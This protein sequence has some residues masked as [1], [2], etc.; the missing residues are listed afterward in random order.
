ML[1]F[2]QDNHQLQ[3]PP[4]IWFRLE[5]MKLIGHLSAGFVPA[6]LK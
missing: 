2:S 4:E 1:G 5:D 6:L 3:T